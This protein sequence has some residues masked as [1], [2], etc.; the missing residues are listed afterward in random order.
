M[1]N[2]IRWNPMR[3]VLTLSEAMDRMLED[4][5]GV[6]GGQRVFA[7]AMDVVETD[8]G[9]TVKA[10]LPGFNP[11]QIDIRIEGNTLTLRGT[12]EQTNEKQEGQYHVRERRMANFARSVTLPIHVD[13]DKTAAEFENGVLTLTLPKLEQALAKKIAITSGKK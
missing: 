12:A 4:N 2:L 5:F 6:R 11:D 10:E 8:T 3:E 9:F 7:P 13:A 1:G